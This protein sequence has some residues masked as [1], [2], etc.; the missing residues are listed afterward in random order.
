MREAKADT[1][2]FL[3]YWGDRSK[4]EMTEHIDPISYIESTYHVQLKR[5]SGDNIAVLVLF[6]EA[7][8]VFTSGAMLVIIGAGPV[9]V[10]AAKKDGL[11]IWQASA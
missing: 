2:G 4:R 7:R 3:L 5:A 10:T 11:T 6:A 1:R 9:P 8:T